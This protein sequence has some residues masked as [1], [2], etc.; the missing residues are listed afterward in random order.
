MNPLMSNPLVNLPGPA[1]LLFYVIL[2]VAAVL[3]T[4]FRTKALDPT[5]ELPTPLL[6]TQFEPLEIAYLR[7]GSPELLR[8]T[9]LDLIA[10]GYLRHSDVKEGVIQQ[11][12]KQLNP[13][14]LSAYERAVFDAMVVPRTA[15]EIF[16]DI[17]RRL[18]S[19]GHG[20][21]LRRELAERNF[22]W[23][24]GEGGIA[25]AA[26]LPALVVVLGIGV[27]KLLVAM[28]RGRHNYG[29]LIILLGV[30]AVAILLAARRGRLTALG[31]TYLERL[32]DGLS[33][34]KERVPTFA[35]NGMTD[36]ITLAVA[37]FGIGILANTSYAYYPVMFQRAAQQN[38]GG[39]CGSAGTS[40]C[41]SS[42]SGSS[43]G[44]DGGDGGG[45]GGCGGCG[46]GGC[47]S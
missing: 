2:I 23:K 4:R 20:E 42:S 40:S 19:A 25:G 28:A 10:R 37:V 6:P 43:S 39:G 12:T 9:I 17:E 22:L 16:S 11:G 34:L 41:G 35:S 24:P 21:N 18:A 3:W 31:R 30:A 36:Q 44:S 7:G 1:F 14:Y 38:S 8:V 29:F 33:S 5:R 27:W 15:K 47:G 45:G 46:G 13:D 26:A 32:R